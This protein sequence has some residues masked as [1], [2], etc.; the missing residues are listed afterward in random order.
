M[1]IYRHR[2]TPTQLVR[3]LR[4]GISVLENHNLT[5]NHWPSNSVKT[6]Q[7]IIN[8]LFWSTIPAVS[9]LLILYYPSGLTEPAKRKP[10]THRNEGIDIVCEDCVPRIW[11]PWLCWLCC[12]LTSHSPA[13]HHVKDSN[14]EFVPWEFSSQYQ[15]VQNT[16][17]LSPGY[18]QPAFFSQNESS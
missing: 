6:K 2:R 1:D 9:C 10:I 7:L 8:R 3:Q 14:T 4:L 18:H 13:H 5:N 11:C 16:G 12:L 15:P 17:R